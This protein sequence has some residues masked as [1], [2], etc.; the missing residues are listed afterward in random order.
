VKAAEVLGL[1]E[2]ELWLP[3]RGVLVGAV[4]GVAG[5]FG[6]PGLLLVPHL[7][8]PFLI[9]SG[10]LKAAEALQMRSVRRRQLS[11]LDGLI[12]QLEAM[13]AARQIAGDL[14]SY[15]DGE[16]SNALSSVPR[17]VEDLF[18]GRAEARLIQYRI[19]RGA[20]DPVARQV[21]GLCLAA[22][23][24]DALVAHVWA[25][26]DEPW[27]TALTGRLDACLARC[28]SRQVVRERWSWQLGV[29]RSLEISARS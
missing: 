6:K 4:R 21:H 8:G 16:A 23:D 25:E 14:S 3:R 13:H 11:R 24:D 15:R 2:D 10:A 29:Q 9:G 20:G 1:I 7:L 22:V 5:L 12:T 18:V 27:I 17:A 28:V 26:R 19:A